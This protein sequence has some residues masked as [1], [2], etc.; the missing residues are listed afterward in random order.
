MVAQLERLRL[1]VL[2]ERLPRPRRDCD[3]CEQKNRRRD[4]LAGGRDT[5]QQCASSMRDEVDHPSRP[6]LLLRLPVAF[7]R[8]FNLTRELQEHLSFIVDEERESRAGTDNQPEDK[9][10]H[11]FPPLRYRIIF[12]FP[13]L[14]LAEKQGAPAA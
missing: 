4:P 1:C 11:K 3:N 9:C 12:K 13:R 10:A 6:T 2:C 14:N 8:L 7:S 5:R